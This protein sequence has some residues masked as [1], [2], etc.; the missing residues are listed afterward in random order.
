M[1]ENA[2]AYKNWRV[3]RD[4]DDILWLYLDRE[5]EK[6]NSLSSAVLAELEAIISDAEKNTPKG[7][8]LISAKPTGFIFGADIREFGGYTDADEVTNEIG[9][10]HGMFNRLE[11]LRCTT[12]A[13][14]EGYCL[15]GGLELS[16]ACDYR[17]AKDVKSTKIG[18]PEVQLGIFPGF[19]GSARSV[20]QI[21]GMKAME[22][23]LTA[24]QLSA[25]RARGVGLVDALVGRHESLYWAARRAVLS[26]KKSRGP[27]LLDKLTNLG[28]A[29]SFLAG[30]MRQKTASKARKEHYPALYSL[31]DTWQNYGGDCQTMMREEAKAVGKLMVSSQAEGLRRV[32]GLME[33]LKSEGKQSDFRARRV[34]VVG[35]GVMG[36]DIA[37]WCVVRGLNVSLQDREMKYIEPALKR[38]Q[39]LFKKK[40]RD[41]AKVKAAMDRLQPDVDGSRVAQADVVI[42]AIFENLEAK[43]ALFKGIEPQLKPDAILATNTSAIPLEDIAE[44]LDKP[45]R[46]I[47][48]HFFNPVPKMPLVEVVAGKQ[49]DKESLKKGAAF[50]G[51]IS[52]FPLPVKS[53]PGFLVNRVL[54]PYMVEALTLHLEGTPVEA[55]DAAAEAFGMP[56]GP[57]E[58]AD[59]VGL[60]VGLSV[61][62]ML[63]GDA[64][65]KE[66]AYIKKYVDEGKLGKKSGQGIYRWENDKPQKN[67][68]A[69]SGHDLAPIAARLIKAYTDEC[70]KTLKEKIVADKDL[71]DAGMVFGTGFAPFR[72]GPM[73]YLAH[74]DEQPT[75]TASGVA[76]APAPE[77]KKTAEVST[78][79]GNPVNT[80]EQQ[81]ESKEPEQAPPGSA[82]KGST[83]KPSGA[84]ADSD[85]DAASQKAPPGAAAKSSSG[86][87]A[88]AKKPAAKKRA[89]AKKTSASTAKKPSSKT[90]AAAK[91]K[92][93]DSSDA[94]SADKP[95]DNKGE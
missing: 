46:L 67:R 55:I 41:P 93:N 7:L 77:A 75:V 11:N 33:R 76:P 37:A 84:N 3:E 38:A 31:I 90:S 20:H 47:G 25:K 12:V 79:A 83:S 54:A 95:S 40:L 28:P 36:G 14:I 32:F 59:T 63:G 42:E 26:K 18:F 69:V 86:K 51:Q 48:L 61:T 92:S 56:M 65:E 45:E 5:G 15:G 74:A 8:V 24:R 72:G 85:K 50:C 23:M 58:L 49:S 2:N 66:Q 82:A 13:A 94:E 43:Q 22:L 73:H 44:A 88:A 57:V 9:R 35:A 16:L 52:R 29:R 71:L 1:T 60:D 78:S 30:K 19:G 87:A 80:S 27:G 81:T 10:V 64:T 21:G 4:K 62:S 89:P 70:E 17:I 53:S 6:V 39:K 34:H 91:A 68:E